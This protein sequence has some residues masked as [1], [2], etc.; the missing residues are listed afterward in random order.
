MSSFYF[1]NDLLVV[2][3]KREVVEDDAALDEPMAK[4]LSVVRWPSIGGGKQIRGGERRRSGN[5]SS[6]VDG[7][8]QWSRS[9]EAQDGVV[10]VVLVRRTSASASWRQLYIGF[11]C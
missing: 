5:S 1:S 2:R 6:A 10:G 7:L 4:L 8:R 11:S 3:L 9:S